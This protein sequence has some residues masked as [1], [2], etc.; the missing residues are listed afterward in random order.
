M[1]DDELALHIAR[2]GPRALPPADVQARVEAQVAEAWRAAVGQAAGA[3]AMARRRRI[4][5]IAA[6]FA[7]VAVFGGGALV[8]LRGGGVLPWGAQPAPA[9][10]VLARGTLEVSPGTDAALLAPGAAL[11]TGMALRAGGAVALRTASGADVRLAAG[12]RIRIDDARAVELL[13]GAIYVDAAQSGQA[14]QVR[15]GEV[16][17]R[18]IGTQFAVE[19]APGSAEVAVR[20]REGAVEV[21]VGDVAG[22]PRRLAVVGRLGQALRVRAGTVTQSPLATDDAAWAWTLAAGTGFGRKDATVDEFLGWAAREQGLR[23]RYGDAEAARTA[24][25][26]RVLGDVS[27]L[28]APEAL[29]AVLASTSLARAEPVAAD[30]ELRIVRGDVARTE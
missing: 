25:G 30:G 9:F 18:D 13:E 26:T 17:V 19:H 11:T 24:R 29:L 20:V 23:L 14:L 3:R 12:S 5:A 7:L 2:A 27:G 21:R 15:A 16:A 28:P 4:T 6:L 1:D 10:A 22:T 8:H